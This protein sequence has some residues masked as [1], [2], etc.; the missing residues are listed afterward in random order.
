MLTTIHIPLPE[1][2][3]KTAQFSVGGPHEDVEMSTYMQRIKAGFREMT[4]TKHY[5]YPLQ[6]VFYTQTKSQQ[7]HNQRTATMSQLANLEEFIEDPSVFEIP[8]ICFK[9]SY[10]KGEAELYYNYSL[11][12]HSG[13]YN[14]S[15]DEFPD[16]FSLTSVHIEVKTGIMYIM[17]GGTCKKSKLDI[18]WLQG[19]ELP[20]CIPSNAHLDREIYLG[21]P[22]ED[23]EVMTYTHAVKHG[24]RHLTV[25]AHHCY[26][27]QEVF[28]FRDSSVSDKSTGNGTISQ[29]KNL[30]LSV[31]DPSVFDVPDICH[32]AP[33]SPA[34]EMPLTLGLLPN[35]AKH[36]DY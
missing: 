9:S 12:I 20:H 5:C 33:I 21:G 10:N 27:I 15:M 7:G 2:A 24:V 6:E 1:S 36:F 3:K 30:K 28:Y 4:V 26:P 25:S 11:G 14:L 34:P 17:T 23:I 13:F 31:D 22:H 35:F 18:S 19:T 16:T 29:V 8:S 32:K